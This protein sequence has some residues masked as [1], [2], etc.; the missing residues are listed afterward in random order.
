MIHHIL[1]IAV[2]LAW[3]AVVALMSPLLILAPWFLNSQ[4][5]TWLIAVGCLLIASLT[6]A[7]PFISSG[8]G[9]IQRTN[10]AVEPGGATYL[11]EENFNATG[12]D[13]V[14]TESLGTPN[15]D[16]ATSP[17]PLEGAQSILLDNTSTTQRANSPTFAEQSTVHGYFLLNVTS[18][19]DSGNSDTYSF[20][21]NTTTICTVQLNASGAMRI[22]CGAVNSSATVATVTEGTTYHVWPSYTAGTGANAAASLGFSTDGTKPTSGN[23]F[24]SMSNGTSTQGA[25]S[26]RLSTSS[27]GTIVI[28]DKVRV[29]D[30]EIGDNPE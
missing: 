11:L 9:G 30:E 3:I 17:A 5:R 16:Y 14:W 25:D 22:V 26:I 1:I 6:Q 19:P 8:R 12:Y 15:E 27:V 18:L 24:T 10:E 7:Q 28:I 21:S 23:N 13:L 20:K 2:G 4:R 29:D